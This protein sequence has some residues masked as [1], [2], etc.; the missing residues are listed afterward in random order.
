MK[1]IILSLLVLIFTQATMAG[2]FDKFIGGNSSSSEKEESS[3]DNQ[4]SSESSYDDEVR[5]SPSLKEKFQ[6][7]FEAGLGN[8]R[9]G[10]NKNTK[11]VRGMTLEEAQAIQDV[12]FLKHQIQKAELKLLVL[13]QKADFVKKKK[14]IKLNKKS[15]YIDIFV[16]FNNQSTIVFDQE[17]L[18][19]SYL[20]QSNI[21][22]QQKEGTNNI[23]EILNK[24]P[25]LSINVKIKF[26][27]DSEYTFVMQTGNT[28]AKRYV[29]YKIYTDYTS[30]ASKTLFLKKTKVRTIHNDFNNKSLYLILSRISKNDF[31]KKLRENITQVDKVLFSGETVIEGLYGMTP[32]DYTLVLN[33]VYE[34]PFIK[35]SKDASAKKQRLILMEMTITNN[36]LDRTLTVNETI[37]KNRFD[38]LVAAYLGNVEME[39]NI[40]PPGQSLRILIVIEDEVIPENGTE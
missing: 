29:D 8:I 23:L 39:E 5:I 30:V 4:G 3:S 1:K 35:T 11:R 6:S 20:Q 19:M 26:I 16:P 13:A 28:E 40:I 12:E 34:S 33:N 25:D 2:P 37:I 7:S 22:I 27:D 24:N 32:I 10:D 18:E 15:R 17:I 21:T 14:E 9:T 36:L 31:Y 38:N